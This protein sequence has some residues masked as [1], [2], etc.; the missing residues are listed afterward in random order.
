MHDATDKPVDRAS[1]QLSLYLV[2]SIGCLWLA[3]PRCKRKM[4]CNTTLQEKTLS[5]QLRSVILLFYFAGRPKP[6]PPP[7]LN[8]NPLAGSRSAGAVGRAAQTSGGVNWKKKRPGR[9]LR[10]ASTNQWRCTINSFFKRGSIR[11]SNPSR[12]TRVVPTP[13]S[14]TMA[15]YSIAYF[16]SRSITV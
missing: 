9:A 5:A 8:P 4:T 7:T 2:S 6:N 12:G 14:S 11:A 15:R 16:A 10:P 13:V 1:Q 3:T